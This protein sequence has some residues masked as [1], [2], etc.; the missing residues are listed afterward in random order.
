MILYLEPRGKFALFGSPDLKQWRKLSDLPIPGGH[1]CPDMFALPVDG[2]PGN[3]RWVVWE[4]GGLYLIGQFDGTTFSPE[5]GSLA[6][7]FGGNDY[8][9][10]TYSDIPDADGRRIQIS[11]MS[12]N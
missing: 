4:G 3:R 2:D 10:Q 5:S 6:S 9:A 8:A 12:G 11:W 7:K 1:E